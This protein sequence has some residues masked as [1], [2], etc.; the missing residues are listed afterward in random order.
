MPGVCVC[1]CVSAAEG[2]NQE[3]EEIDGRLVIEAV[4]GWQL[5]V[6]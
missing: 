1:V 6:T 3:E 5:G 2:F 4:A